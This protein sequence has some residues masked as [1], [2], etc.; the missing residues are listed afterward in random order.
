MYV[1]KQF[2]RVVDLL[3]FPLI[4]GVVF[5][6]APVAGLAL[7]TSFEILT[8]LCVPLYFI[9][10]GYFFFY[11]KN[12]D[13]QVYRR[14]IVKRVRT[15]L[16]PYLLWN[17]IALLVWQ[18]RCRMNIGHMMLDAKFVLGSFWAT[19]FEN[20]SDAPIDYPLWFV[21]DLMVICL[22]SPVVYYALRRVGIL[23]LVATGISWFFDFNIPVPGFSS[24]AVFFFSVGAYFSIRRVDPLGMPH[25][26]ALYAAWAL[27][28][29][30]FL[31]AQNSSVAHIFKNLN[32]L[33]G[34]PA[35]LTACAAMMHAHIPPPNRFLNN[36]TFFIF[37][38]HAL[39]I[40]NISSLIDSVVPLA[41][42]VMFFVV[43]TVTI[44][45]CLCCY[46]IAGK[47]APRIVDVLTGSRG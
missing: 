8:G 41:P 9:I 15:L 22:L 44:A 21:R 10:S 46:A 16:I 32:I 39:I 19:P 27:S 28:A 3:R 40:K 30:C 34:I 47:C 14:N 37:A 12:F 13:M 31:V 35:V 29:L 25:R 45:V 2:E 6:H 23:W 4:A 1:N 11:G 5:I 26:K 43:P 7:K 24:I 33:L 18:L 42:A 20:G 38:F 17:L 36:S